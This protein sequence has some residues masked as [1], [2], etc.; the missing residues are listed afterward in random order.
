MKIEENSFVNNVAAVF[1]GQ[2][3][4]KK[5]QLRHEI[6]LLLQSGANLPDKL[7]SSLKNMLSE[8]MK[9]KNKYSDSISKSQLRHL[10]WETVEDVKNSIVH[11]PYD[12][13]MNHIKD[14]AHIL[15]S[16]RDVDGRHHR[17]LAKW[18]D[19]LNFALKRARGTPNYAELEHKYEPA[20]G[21]IHRAIG[22]PVRE[23]DESPAA[24][25]NQKLIEKWIAEF[26]G[27]LSKTA[28]KVLSS[29][30]KSVLPLSLE[31]LPDTTTVGDAVEEIEIAL[32]EKDYNKAVRMAGIW[33][34]QIANE[35]AE[36]HGFGDAESLF[37][38]QCNCG[39]DCKCNRNKK[40]SVNEL[41]QLV[42]ECL[43]EVLAEAAKYSDPT[44]EEML[45]FLLGIYG[46]EGKEE[47]ETAIYYFAMDNHT[48]QSSNLY[49]ALSTSPYTPGPHSTKEKEGDG[50]VEMYKDL[51][52]E[53][54]SPIYDPSS[55]SHDDLPPGEEYELPKGISEIN[56]DEAA[57][58]EDSYIEELTDTIERLI[59][60]VETDSG[61][62]SAFG[63]LK[64]IE[65]NL[66]SVIDNPRLTS[67]EK[68]K[69]EAIYTPLLNKIYSVTKGGTS[70][71]PEPVM[72]EKA[73]PGTSEKTM[74]SLKASL[75][76][77]HPDW[78][79]DKVKQVAFATA[80]KVHKK[81]GSTVK[82]A[83]KPSVPLSPNAILFSVP[84]TE[85]DMAA[86]KIKQSPIGQVNLPEVGKYDIY[87][88]YID[89]GNAHCYLVLKKF[90][91]GSP[92]FVRELK[93][94]VTFFDSKSKPVQ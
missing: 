42:N 40:I 62:A 4:A 33:A 80:W 7:V 52:N 32:Q 25:K 8:N 57:D 86:E 50:V 56:D 88:A 91:D 12:E 75:R 21:L 90:V 89:K 55:G 92:V 38:K 39:C 43:N 27:D 47:A 79:E 84:K 9:N 74:H 10:V 28:Y 22:E 93:R 3:E 23:S 61:N 13:M 71:A 11:L 6:E 49:S 68:Q 51:E 65:R 31:D 67:F 72:T 63:E 58:F 18:A 87:A 16:K 70:G 15:K 54:G 85:Y 30:A 26:N 20:L 94:N 1:S 2:D 81:K 53:Y 29:I 59:Q 46:P 60:Q 5:D 82:E 45:R 37:E 24:S 73:P 64:K 17:N 48:G 35:F 83:K 78:S 44:R 34:R 14:A 36:E 41:K 77:S 76:K 19:D 69:W 66:E